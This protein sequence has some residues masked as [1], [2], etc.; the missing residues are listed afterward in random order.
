MPDADFTAFFDRITTGPWADPADPGHRCG[1]ALAALADAVVSGHADLLATLAPQLEALVAAAPVTTGASRY[2][3][4]AG[5]GGRLGALA[6]NGNGTHPIV[7]P[8]NPMAPPI[9][10]ST[11]RDDAGEYVVGEVVYDC[12]FEGLPGLAQ[13]G[14][15]AAAFDVLL[16]QAV[17]LGGQRGVTGSL[18]VRYLAPTPLYVPLR[19]E[20]RFA[21]AEGRKRTVTG[22]LL[23]AADGRVTAEA[24]GVFIA[25]RDGQII[26]HEPTD[27][28][29]K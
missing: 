9:L 19:Y 3:D 22:R 24:E 7:G 23:V 28:G 1:R 10:L 26:Q 20:T 5:H 18:S 14:F 25:P 2:D 11:E 8:R 16:G 21:H 15:V 4:E 6:P 29:P 27:G 13:G 12:R 17:A